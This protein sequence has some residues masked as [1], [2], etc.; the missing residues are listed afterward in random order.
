M[1][2][3]GFMGGFEGLG[4]LLGDGQGFVERDRPFGDPICER[5]PFDEFEDQRL[6]AI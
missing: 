3:A 2:D 1:D 6:L 4:D 5:G